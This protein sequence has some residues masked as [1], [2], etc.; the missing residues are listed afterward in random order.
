M[1]EVTKNIRVDDDLDE[2]RGF[3]DH[4]WSKDFLEVTRLTKLSPAGFDLMAAW[5]GISEARRFPWLMIQVVNA[6]VEGSLNLATPFPSQVLNE[7]LDRVTAGLERNRLS[8]SGKDREALCNEIRTI[9][10]QISQRA[11]RNSVRLDANEL[12]THFLQSQGIALSLLMSEVNAYAAVYFAYENYLIRSVKIGKGLKNLRARNLPGKLEELLGK[13]VAEMCWSEK[14]I[15]MS[16]LVRHAIA[17][18]GRKITDDLG[19]YRSKL[20]L[21]NDEIMIMAHQTTELY[22]LLKERALLFTI[23]MVKLPICRMD[24]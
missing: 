15:E 8:L 23:E 17:H 9:E 10:A 1:K 7:L 6:A 22:N 24:T 20:I 21:E 13:S 4:K 5:K 2:Y 14:G 11:K 19:K 18:G 12:W 3:F 16:R